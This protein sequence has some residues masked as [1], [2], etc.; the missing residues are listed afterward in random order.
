MHFS[1][2]VITFLILAWIGLKWRKDEVY[3]V[4]WGGCDQSLEW[5]NA[6]SSLHSKRSVITPLW[7]HSG[8]YIPAHGK[9]APCSLR[10]NVIR[11][12]WGGKKHVAHSR[13]AGTPKINPASA[14]ASDNIVTP[15]ASFTVGFL[16]E[17]TEQNLNFGTGL[18][19]LIIIIF[20]Q[21]PTECITFARAF[22][23]WELTH[24]LSIYVPPQIAIRRQLLIIIRE[25]CKC[26]IDLIKHIN[27]QVLHDFAL[28]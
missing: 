4:C 6:C 5:I 25:G 14:A 11:D 1:N 17:N 23:S 12:N 18:R 21:V 9:T 8:F 24:A 22:E 20:P 13:S 19:L 10:L 27:K 3:S 26:D 16:V 15:L 7:I 28:Y 2:S